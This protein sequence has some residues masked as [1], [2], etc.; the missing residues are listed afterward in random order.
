MLSAQVDINFLPVI[1]LSA[2]LD[3]GV[4]AYGTGT[5]YWGQVDA[6]NNPLPAPKNENGG[7]VGTVTYDVT[8]NEFDPAFSAQEDYQPGVSGIPMQLWKTA[9][10]RRR[11]LRQD[12]IGRSRSSTASADCTP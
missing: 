3:W 11:H 9:Q 12:G 4:Q 1:G 2:K 10:E 8:R 7:I 5:D 6:N